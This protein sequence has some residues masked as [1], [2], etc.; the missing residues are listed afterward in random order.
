MQMTIDELFQLVHLLIVDPA[1]GDHEP[2]DPDATPPMGVDRT[3]LE[4]LTDDY[5]NDLVCWVRANGG[6][7][8]FAPH[9]VGLA[10]LRHWFGQLYDERDID[11][12]DAELALHVRDVFTDATR[13]AAEKASI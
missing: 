7:G 1:A 4:R 8:Q 2:T 11:C 10:A 3:E 12:T 13:A 9:V 5:L 6:M